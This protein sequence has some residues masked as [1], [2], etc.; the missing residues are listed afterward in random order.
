MKDELGRVPSGLLHSR[1]K[2]FDAV[3][4]GERSWFPGSLTARR[5]TLGRLQPVPEER[6]ARRAYLGNTQRSRRL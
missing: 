4:V 1:E 5:Q 6:E 2:F 3:K